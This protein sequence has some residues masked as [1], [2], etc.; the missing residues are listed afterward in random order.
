MTT[1][2]EEEELDCSILLADGDCW[3]A[4]P[5]LLDP[6]IEWDGVLAIQFK[7]GGLWWLSAK[8]RKWANVEEPAKKPDTG[9]R[10]VK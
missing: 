1:E 5:D 9:M 4:D 3:I 10:R 6:A 7:D 8:T 2:P